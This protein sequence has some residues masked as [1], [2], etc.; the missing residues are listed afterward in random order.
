M[1]SNPAQT[2]YINDT[3]SLCACLATIQKLAVQKAVKR[4]SP[5]HRETPTNFY[6]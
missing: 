3:V 5:A 6:K 4:N 2:N 1:T